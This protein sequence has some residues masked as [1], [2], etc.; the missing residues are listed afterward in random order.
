MY[1]KITYNLSES[2]IGTKTLEHTNGAIYPIDIWDPLFINQWNFKKVPQNVVTAIP[3]LRSNAKLTDLISANYFGSAF[4]LTIST[5]LKNILEKYSKKNIE[6]I[7]IKMIQK[8]KEIEGY[9]ITNIIECTNPDVI[10][11]SECQI[12]YWMVKNDQEIMVN[13][14]HEF[15]TAKE[16]LVEGD[17]SLFIYKLVLKQT[18]QDDL[19][20]LSSIKG[21]GVGY[22]IS[23]NVKDEI[24]SLGCT[25]IDFELIEQA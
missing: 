4:R 17:S 23:Q 21:G 3:K 7:P 15:L 25:G 9:W 10:N 5:K 6:F 11:F 12:K 2:V 14:Y 19:I 8:Q 18:A 22:Y 1:Y 20:I 24:Q 16:K 13:N